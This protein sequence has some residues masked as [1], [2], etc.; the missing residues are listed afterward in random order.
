MPHS[1]PL[2]EFL[3]FD[4][5]SN[6]VLASAMEP[7]R[8]V[9]MRAVGAALDWRISGLNEAAIVSS[10]H[11]RV[12]PDQIFR[13]NTQRRA[14]ILVA[15]YGIAQM[16]L[17][18]IARQIRRAATSSELLIA[19]DGAPLLL[20]EAGLLDG[21]EATM[22]WHD[23]EIF[24]ERFSNITVTHQRFV[25]AG[26]IITC[27]GA[28]S[29]LDMMLDLIRQ[30]FGTAAAFDASTMFLYDPERQQSISSSDQ[31]GFQQTGSDRVL[32]A[33]DKM[34]A[35]IETP[36]PISKIAQAASTSVRSLNR[37][38]LNELGITPGKY[39]RMLRLKRAR[40]MAQQS[41]HPLEQIAHRCGFSTASA[42]SRAYAKPMV[43]KNLWCSDQ[44]SPATGYSADKR[45]LMVRYKKTRGTTAPRQ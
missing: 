44:Q 40:E 2:Y 8:D 18:N 19:V 35:H 34:A 9:K 38:F 12:T 6:M 39:Y 25:R 20:A 13:P 32:R 16:D 3:L 7:L 14:L 17:S 36:A 4:G 23:L 28:S 24:A 30:D 22:H 29:T 41:N 42:L 27:G 33:L 21:R 11:V 5:F 10:S 31:A 37:L 45:T 15:G 26:R 43:F 1:P